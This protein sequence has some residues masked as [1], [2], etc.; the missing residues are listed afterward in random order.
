MKQ[1]EQKFQSMGEESRNLRRRIA[2]LENQQ[3]RFKEIL[4]A[5]AI[6]VVPIAPDKPSKSRQIGRRI[7]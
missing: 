5:I 2:V 7:R 6:T 4:L 3:D 1:L